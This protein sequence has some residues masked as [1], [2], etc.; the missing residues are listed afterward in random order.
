M[1]GT[2]KVLAKS[3]LKMRKENLESSTA[4]RCVTRNEALNK[5]VKISRFG[6]VYS[7]G[8]PREQKKVKGQ[9]KTYYHAKDI[10]FLMHEPLMNV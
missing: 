9:G 7:E 10:A 6:A 3:K 1:N 8:Y 5:P 4:S 2:G